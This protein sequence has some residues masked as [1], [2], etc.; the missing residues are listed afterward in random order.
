MA[1]CLTTHAQIESHLTYRLYTTQDGL[2][3]MQ[4]ERL[5]QDSKGYIYMGTLSG[6]VRFDGRVLTPFLKGRRMNIVGFDEIDGEV[7]A[8]GFFRQWK[9]S[10]DEVEALPLDRQGH[11]LL[12]NLNAGSL[13]GGYVLMEDSLEENRRLCRL[14]KQ[15]TE[16]LLSH[17][18]LDEMTPDRRLLIDTAATV[19]TVPTEKGLYEIRLKSGKVVKLS[20][21]PDIY[22]LLQSDSA[23]LAFASDGVYA[24]GTDSLRQ[25]ATADWTSASYGL[26]VRKLRS[27]HVVIA[28]EH[29]V[30]IYD[31]T[32]IRQVMEGINLIRDMLVDRW[33]RLWLAT[34][35][36]VYC[37]FNRCF[38]NHQLTDKGDIIRAMATDSRGR[39]VA[40]T[41]NGKVMVLDHRAQPTIVSDDPEQFFAPSAVRIGDEVYMSGNGDVVAVADDGNGAT[42]L[43]WLGLPRDRYQFV[44]EAWDQLII[45]TRNAILAYNR[46]TAETDTLTTDILHPW[47]AAKDGKDRLWIGSSSGLFCIDRAHKVSK[48]DYAQKLIISTMDADDKGTVLFASADSLF[49]VRDNR[50]VELNSQLPDLA[51]HEVRSL[52]IS[53]RGYLVVAVIDGLFV[54]RLSNDC[55]ISNVHFYDHRNGFTMLEPLKATM[56]E[57][58]DGT[59]W[60]AGVEQMTS[61]RPAEL[62]AYN[63]EDTYIAPPLSWWQHWWVWLIALVLLALLV[64]VVTRWYDNRRNRRRMIRLEREKMMKVQQI[65]AIR[66]KAMESKPNELAHDIVKMTEEVDDDARITFRTASGIIVVDVKDIAYFKGD[67]NYSQIV[68]FH[69]KDTVLIG[70]GTL[71]KMLNPNTFVRADRSTLVNIH[72]VCQLLPKQRRCLFRSPEGKEV[73]TTLH[74]PAF[75]RLKSLLSCLLLTLVMQAQT[76]ICPPF[77]QAGDRVAVVSPSSSPDAETV[78]KGCETLRQWGYEPVVGKHA[79]DDY[80]GFAGTAD[81]RAA[82]LLW[83]LRDTTIKAI[84]CSRGGD[85]GV[86]VLRRIPLREFR[87]HPKWLIGFSDITALHSAEVSAGVMSIHGSMCHA[88]SSMEGRDTVSVTLRRLLQG[89]LP[90]YHIAHHEHDQAGEAR[91][92]LVG[93]NFSVLCGLAG[94]DY[95]CLNRVDEGLILFIEDTDESMTKVDRMLHLLEIRGILAKLKGIIVGQFNKYKHPENGFKDMYDMFHEYLQEYDI[96]VCYNFPVGH[97]RLRNFPLVEG[98]P[99][100]LKVDS[101]G[102]TVETLNVK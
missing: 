43:R 79:L 15:G 100:H 35:Q 49:M 26:T 44:A 28:D 75:K 2:P 74:A 73:E 19:A 65:E 42:A 32:A 46:T 62:L 81:D 17:K 45:G 70:L 40:G 57:S 23:L 5:W 61:F 10:F 97:A 102:T 88:I 78:E 85:G 64:W 94:S 20:D 27:G 24:V 59:V 68:T 80:H 3:Q 48:V 98:C 21:R 71:E 36:G 72:H 55:R 22:T 33:D 82:D 91:G 93:G 96:P 4:A 83:A 86:Q 60:L 92:M 37:L 87:K 7:R 25:L 13:P 29:S 6:F 69:N 16:L 51:G 58:D 12:N 77:L 95:D 99:V 41:L 84:M 14:T 56:A 8:L 63:E 39:L 89:E 52:H 38:T 47:C 30:Y 1:C 101:T 18:L 90:T 9:V 53:P 11:W 54:A 66:Q 50:V 76:M 31:G 34:Y 67:G